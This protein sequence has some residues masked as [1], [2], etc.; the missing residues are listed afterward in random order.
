[1]ESSEIPE[2]KVIQ[3]NDDPIENKLRELRDH[4]ERM[5]KQ[6]KEIFEKLG[7]GEHQLESIMQNK[8][9]FAPEV[10]DFIQRERQALETVLNRR[11]DEV[12]NSVKK[13]NPAELP[14]VGGHWI[15]VR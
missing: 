6:N 7:I 3:E 12:R 5:E 1:M 10:Y 13:E 15:F 8:D 14:S 9:N 4:I 2:K 11:L